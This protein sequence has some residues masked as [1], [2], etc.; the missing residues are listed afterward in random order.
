MLEVVIPPTQTTLPTTQS[1]PTI[2]I[3]DAATNKDVVEERE[4]E[5]VAERDVDEGVM[6]EGNE[7][8]VEEGN[9]GVVEET[10]KKSVHGGAAH[11]SLQ[12]ANETAV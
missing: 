6:V 10:P 7:G 11:N 4:V 5:A 2:A 12:S 1:T 9:E 3:F 8:A